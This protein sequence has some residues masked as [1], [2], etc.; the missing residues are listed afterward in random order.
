LIESEFSRDKLQPLAFA[1]TMAF[2][3][4]TDSTGASAF[5]QLMP[6]LTARA[7]KVPEIF[8]TTVPPPSHRADLQLLVVAPAPP[9]F[10]L[11]GEGFAHE[12]GL[13]LYVQDVF[14]P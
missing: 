14:K 7:L 4:G 2:G 8:P 3:P 10:Q 13:V 6:V 9:S 12:K 5:R 1:N 11:Q